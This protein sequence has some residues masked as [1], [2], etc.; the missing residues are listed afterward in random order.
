MVSKCCSCC[1]VTQPDEGSGSSSKK[2]RRSKA[3]GGSSNSDKEKLV[4][5]PNSLDS[6]FTTSSRNSA[7]TVLV[8]KYE[9]ELDAKLESGAG[10]NDNRDYDLLVS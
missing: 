5:R 2:K 8:H 9:E 7:G 10:K 6:S 4:K 1:C 3:I